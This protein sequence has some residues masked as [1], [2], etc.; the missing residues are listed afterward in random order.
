MAF[1]GVPFSY[2]L[3]H[4]LAHQIGVFHRVLQGQAFDPVSYTHLAMSAKDEI[5]SY[6]DS[7]KDLYF[8]T[9]DQI[10][11]YAEL[12]L[13]EHKSAAALIDILKN[14]GFQV[15]QGVSDLPTAFLAEFGQG[16][17]V[18]AYP[19]SYTHLGYAPVG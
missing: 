12:G 8:E 1:A 18:I 7:R 14:E 5:I 4:Q 15:T 9:S 3:L 17:P 2:R 16:K 19:V 6:V 11:E 10:W 13:K